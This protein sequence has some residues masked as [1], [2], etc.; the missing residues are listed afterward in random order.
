MHTKRLIKHHS[1][2]DCTGIG[3]TT[4]STKKLKCQISISD[5]DF[6]RVFSVP[7]AHREPTL[8]M[9]VFI[10]DNIEMSTTKK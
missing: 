9:D 7:L 3:I 2:F 10:H 6:D 1:S 8:C 5:F 4:L